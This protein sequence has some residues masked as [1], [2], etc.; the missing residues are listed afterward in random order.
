MGLKKDKEIQ[1]IKDCGVCNVGLVSAMDERIKTAGVSIKR[2]AKQIYAEV[3]ETLGE[4]VFS[5]DAIEARYRRT[6]GLRHPVL[7]VRGGEPTLEREFRRTLSF[8]RTA[9]N[10]LC[11]INPQLAKMEATE[12]S[13]LEGF[14]AKI[15]IALFVEQFTIFSKYFKIQESIADE[16]NRQRDKIAG[17]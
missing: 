11:L 6:K 15:D 13:G 4:E 16:K 17:S 7:D 3:V 8:L 10:K 12:I 5:P 14:L 9:T 1:W 2:A